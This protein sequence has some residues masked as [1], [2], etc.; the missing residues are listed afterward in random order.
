MLLKKISEF[1]S[2]P[3]T[4]KLQLKGQQ[5]KESFHYEQKQAQK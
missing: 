1:S 3:I 5:K 4:T 2:N